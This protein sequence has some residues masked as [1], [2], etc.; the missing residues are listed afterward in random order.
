MFCFADRTFCCSMDCKNECGRQWT[1][2]LQK[3]ADKWAK[4]CGIEGGAPVAFSTFCG[5][6][7][8]LA[9]IGD[10]HVND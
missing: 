10:T 9:L 5:D 3:K 4:E 7:P 2:E 1:D 8:N 6:E